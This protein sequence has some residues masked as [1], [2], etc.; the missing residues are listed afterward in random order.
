MRISPALIIIIIS[1][2]AGTEDDAPTASLS[3]KVIA[4]PVLN[5]LHHDYR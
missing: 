3:G 1:G 2:F 5:G 4:F